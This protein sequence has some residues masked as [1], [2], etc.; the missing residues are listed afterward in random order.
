MLLGR[1]PHCYYAAQAAAFAVEGS[2]PGRRLGVPESHVDHQDLLQT[3]A[4]VSVAL[5]GFSGV[6]TVFGRRHTGEWDPADRLTL[7]FML[8]TSLA[9]LFLSL[10]PLALLAAELSPRSTWIVMSGVLAAFLVV[11]DGA[12]ISRYRRLPSDQQ[13]ALGR[14]LNTASLLGD[15]CVVVLQLFNVFSAHEFS[16]YLIGL[17]WLLFGCALF[18]VRLLGFFRP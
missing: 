13:I 18:F 17:I 11:V 9:A 5:A 16:P 14:T 15:L 4:E 1:S 8:E 10:L 3:L 7:S 2:Q 6:V 12:A